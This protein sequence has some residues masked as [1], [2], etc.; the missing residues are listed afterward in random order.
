[1]PMIPCAGCGT[2]IHRMFAPDTPGLVSSE[3]WCGSCFKTGIVGSLKDGGEE[4]ADAISD[5]IGDRIMPEK[6]TTT[7]EIMARL[8]APFDEALMKFK[9]D[10]GD[11]LPHFHWT[12]Y[13]QRFDDVFGF[14]WTSDC[15]KHGD[16]TFECTI[17][18]MLPSDRQV[19]RSATGEDD[20]ITI[21]D[22]GEVRT[23]PFT[24]RAQAFKRAAVA[25]GVGRYVYALPKRRKGQ[26]SAP[27][28]TTAAAKAPPP[29]KAAEAPRPRAYAKGYAGHDQSPG[30]SLLRKRRMGGR[31]Q[32]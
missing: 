31:R 17:T 8:Q 16:G 6:T 5:F 15:M 14:D 27:Q 7:A 28:R 10:K 18:V 23:I 32:C 19:S 30:R 12:V 29:Q 26:Q 11:E 20:V 1:M 3:A 25:F 2:E 13:Q 22:T 9:P 21:R 24:G 4:I